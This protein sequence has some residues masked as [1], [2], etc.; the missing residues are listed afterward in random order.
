[1]LGSSLDMIAL[2]LTL[3]S[4][5]Q[6]RP[7]GDK[8]VRV[9]LLADRAAI[10]PG[11]RF[12][13]A[14][15]LS[16][17]KGWHV[18]WENPGDSGMPTRLSITAPPGFQIGDPQSPAPEREEAEGDIVTFVHKGDVLFLFDARAPKDLKAGAPIAFD[19]EAR[20]L[21]CQ[22]TCHPGSGK[23]KLSLPV[24]SESAPAN[25]KLFAAA[26]GR[27]P[28]P[29]SELESAVD[30]TGS[31]TSQQ[32]RIDVAKATGL[33]L[34]PLV[35]RSTEVVGTATAPTPSGWRLTADLAVKE[36]SPAEPTRVQ[37]VLV[38]KTAQGESAYRLDAA[39]SGS[40]K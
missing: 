19:L 31:G 26:R 36:I 10:R 18:Y 9:E 40:G 37:G 5:L 3:A 27:I 15:K 38:V 17:E 6:E 29:W 32:L 28:K 34:F 2:L 12:T 33:E 8:L 1:M 22:E 21:V 24:A 23:A 20:W 4:A 11:E 25:E 16:V 14:A 13:L 39:R 7:L 30:W 35:G